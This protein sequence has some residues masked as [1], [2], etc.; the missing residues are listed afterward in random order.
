MMQQ[1]PARNDERCTDLMVARCRKLSLPCLRVE[2]GRV[3]SVGP[4][5][6]EALRDFLSC[7][8]M[9]Q[10]VKGATERQGGEEPGEGM[11]LFE[12]CW[13][14]PLDHSAQYGSPMA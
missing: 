2:D 4:A 1:N 13:L 8:A 11:K 14:L 9:G 10:L 6:D 12:G 3:A 7:P 5:G